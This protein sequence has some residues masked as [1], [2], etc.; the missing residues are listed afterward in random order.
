MMRSN[1]DLF[2]CFT[3]FNLGQV[4]GT[5]RE[6][7]NNDRCVQKYSKKKLKIPISVTQRAR[8]NRHQR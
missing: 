2:K 7:T 5:N 4:Q 6:R 1:R 3:E 8:L